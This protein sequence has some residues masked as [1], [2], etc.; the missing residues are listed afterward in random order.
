MIPSLKHNNI[1]MKS[2]LSDW[3]TREKIYRWADC[4]KSFLYIVSFLTTS[5]I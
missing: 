5:F 4:M 3:W 1:V 2:I